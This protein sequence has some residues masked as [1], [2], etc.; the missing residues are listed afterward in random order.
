LLFDDKNAK[1]FI[2]VVNFFNEMDHR[3]RETFFKKKAAAFSAAAGLWLVIY[4]LFVVAKGNYLL[5]V[6]SGESRFTRLS[7]SLPV[8]GM[9]S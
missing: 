6:L 1:K 7:C 8:R 3:I 2:V 4:G 5:V 9:Y